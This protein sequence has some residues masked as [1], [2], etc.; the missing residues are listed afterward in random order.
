MFNMHSSWTFLT[1]QRQ[2]NWLQLY[3]NGGIGGEKIELPQSHSP[4]SGSKGYF[5]LNL[6]KHYLH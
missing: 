4:A 6:K 2:G 3:A 5:D 1:N